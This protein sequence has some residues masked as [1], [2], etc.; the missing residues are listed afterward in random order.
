MG[1]RVSS[2]PPYDARGW[3]NTVQLPGVGLLRLC[4][5]EMSKTRVGDHRGAYVVGLEIPFEPERQ[6]QRLGHT[7]GSLTERGLDSKPQKRRAHRKNHDPL[8]SGVAGAT[9]AGPSLFA[10]TITRGKQL[11][12]RHRSAVFAAEIEAHMKKREKENTPRRHSA[13]EPSS[14]QHDE[15]PRI[16]VGKPLHKNGA[17]QQWFHWGTGSK[18]YP[19]ERRARD[20]VDVQEQEADAEM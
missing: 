10:G 8:H 20:T 14:L 19:V 2:M 18:L 7:H 11:Q 5:G 6:T 3:N 13:E 16:T 15:K 17:G 1:R 12:T 9:T 4:E